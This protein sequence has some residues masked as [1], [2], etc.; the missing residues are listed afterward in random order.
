[1]YIICKQKW[2]HIVFVRWKAEHMLLS[3]TLPGGV[4]TF[5]NENIWSGIFGQGEKMDLLQDVFVIEV[6]DS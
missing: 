3:A 1:M 6:I 5:Q 2:C 4:H